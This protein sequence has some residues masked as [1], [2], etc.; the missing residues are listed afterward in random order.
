MSMP[1]VKTC[2]VVA[3]LAA[4]CTGQG[5]GETEAMSQ[6]ETEAMST[7]TDPSPEPSSPDIVTVPP[8]GG[9]HS[10]G[11]LQEG[12]AIERLDDPG[13]LVAEVIVFE[14]RAGEAV[15]STRNDLDG[16]AE[17]LVSPEPIRGYDVV[18]VF[19]PSP[20][21]GA[22]P[23]VSVEA[24]RNPVLLIEEA[25]LP[26]ETGCDAF[27]GISYLGI[28]WADGTSIELTDADVDYR[29]QR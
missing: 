14:P 8:Y 10:Q 25:A 17:V 3:L 21:C 13:R 11:E 6:G 24:E 18:V 19:A 22:L 27:F 23:I 26:P 29:H 28:T 9:S 15:P 5:Q 2:L 12:I 1:F 4:S 7:A 20:L 16:S